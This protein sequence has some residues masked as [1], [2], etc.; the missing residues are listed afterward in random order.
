MPSLL[1]F[2][3]ANELKGAKGTKVKVLAKD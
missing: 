3:G 2:M 1:S